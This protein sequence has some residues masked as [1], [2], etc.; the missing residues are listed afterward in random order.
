V[1]FADDVKLELLDS[2]GKVVLAQSQASLK[3][4]VHE[5]S[6]TLDKGRYVLRVQV[7]DKNVAK[8][9]QTSPEKYPF[10]FIVK[11]VQ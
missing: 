3:A 4:P 5:F 9:V 11:P 10:S 2:T 1:Q 6:A 8:L 7:L